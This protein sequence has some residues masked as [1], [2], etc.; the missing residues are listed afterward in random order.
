[1]ALDSH[2]KFRLEKLSE[3]GMVNDR[4]P[5]LLE[6]LRVLDLTEGDAMISVG[7]LADLGADVIKVEKPSGS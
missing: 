2:S 5:M 6:G 4:A 7:I 3:M 1:M